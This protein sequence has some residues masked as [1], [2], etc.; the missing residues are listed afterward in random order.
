M[1]KLIFEFGDFMNNYFSYLLNQ[2]SENEKNN[3]IFEFYDFRNEN[4]IFNRENID[5]RYIDLNKQE[6]QDFKKKI[7]NF[8][9]YKGNIFSLN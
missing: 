4:F 6:L 2:N 1:T 7:K 5:K 8:N 3:L 9:Y